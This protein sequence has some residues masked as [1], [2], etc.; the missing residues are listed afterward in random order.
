M[1]AVLKTDAGLVPFGVDVRERAARH[2]V[3]AVIVG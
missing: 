2:P 1:A 3:N